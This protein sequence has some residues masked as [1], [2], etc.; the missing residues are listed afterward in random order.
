MSKR[1]PNSIC[2]RLKTGYRAQI[3]SRGVRG[4]LAHPGLLL[5]NLSAPTHQ[6]QPSSWDYRATV[7]WVGRRG[8]NEQP[9]KENRPVFGH[10]A[11]G[12]SHSFP[13]SGPRSSPC[14]LLK[15]CLTQSSAVS[16]ESIARCPT[17][18]LCYA[19]EARGHTQGAPVLTPAHAGNEKQVFT[20]TRKHVHN[21]QSHGRHHRLTAQEHT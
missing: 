12:L 11:V 4:H 7:V 6:A 5:G 16:I 14:A 15:S 21:V 20:A 3:G 2:Q 19:E 10:T 18:S 1:G 17:A 8:A 13:S 9:N